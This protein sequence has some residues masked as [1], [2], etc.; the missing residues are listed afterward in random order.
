MKGPRSRT[1]HNVWRVWE[2]KRCQQRA[3]ELPQVTTRICLCQGEGTPTWMTLLDPPR[4][5][6]LKT[7]P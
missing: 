6:N 7:V 2:C 3:F 4:P 5:K 1:R